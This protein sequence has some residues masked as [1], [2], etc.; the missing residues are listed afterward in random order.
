MKLSSST[1]YSETDLL[2]KAKDEKW[3]GNGTEE[4]PFIIE[5]THSFLDQS[6]IKTS[7]LHIIMKN[8][9]FKT[10]MLNR[11]R[12]I[13]FEDCVFEYLALSKCS[14]IKIKSCSFQITLEFRYSHNSYI[15]GSHIPFLI[16]SM[17]YENH[18]KTCK[19]TKIYNYFSRA[20]T[21]EDIDSPE[22]FGIV[23]RRGMKKY[24]L[25][26]LGFIAVGIVSLVSAII[27]YFNSNL[28]STIWLVG[29]LFLMAFIT[30]V[31]TIGLYLDYRNMQH[32]PDNQIS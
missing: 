20:N 9:N 15:E 18:F 26:F 23:M 31:G 14:K 10:F 1:K 30:F 3:I 7:A 29:G 32:H 4:N 6:T 17:C 16:F 19:I 2:Q 22:D 5:S 13:K 8:C 11:C 27:V 25:K 28:D 12:N 21:F 24:Y